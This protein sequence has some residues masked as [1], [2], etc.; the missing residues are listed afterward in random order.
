MTDHDELRRLA[1]AATEIPNGCCHA[2]AETHHGH[3]LHSYMDGSAVKLPWGAFIAAANPATVI[4]LLDERD[5]LLGALNDQ[6][7]WGNAVAERDAARADLAAANARAKELT[8]ACLEARSE[9]VR[10]RERITEYEKDSADMARQLSDASKRAT[11]AEAMADEWKNARTSYVDDLSAKYIDQQARIDKALALADEWA[12]GCDFC[13]FDACH[14]SHLRAALAADTPTPTD[15]CRCGHLRGD[16]W[17]GLVPPKVGIC[18]GST[19]GCQG[20]AADTPTTATAEG[21]D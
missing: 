17:K 10:L 4:A 11:H 3:F 5:E 7:D 15:R 21:S 19:C 2:D 6:C 16:H 9:G 1:Q 20:F 13:E 14:C 12:R 8:E 18:A